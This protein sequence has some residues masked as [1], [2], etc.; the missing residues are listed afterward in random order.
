MYSGANPVNSGI[1]TKN[2]E[3]GNIGSI[4]H[5]TGET[6]SGELRFEPFRY[7]RMHKNCEEPVYNPYFYEFNENGQLV[8]NDRTIDP[9][10]NYTPQK[11]FKD[12]IDSK[13]I[14][15]PESGYQSILLEM[16]T[17]YAAQQMQGPEE[18]PDGWIYIQADGDIVLFYMQQNGNYEL[19]TISD[20]ID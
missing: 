3:G 5:G 20:I 16:P 19:Q 2:T 6:G 9:G 13:D 18:L 15:F 10:D 7:V 14:T 12:W 17:S 4:I 8:R 11:A 1:I